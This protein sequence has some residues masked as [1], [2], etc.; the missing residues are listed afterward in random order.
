MKAAHH[1]LLSH[2]TAT[3]IIRANVPQ[4]KV[5][6][7]LNLCPAYPRR[8]VRPIGRPMLF[9]T[10]RLIDGFWILSY[11]ASYPEDVI[12]ERFRLKQIPEPR[13]DYVQAGDL[14]QMSCPP[15]S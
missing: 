3:E 5:G 1:L 4:A 15:I 13:L 12:Q 11:K 10:G 8:P 9:L 7:T 2:G 6:I 14:E